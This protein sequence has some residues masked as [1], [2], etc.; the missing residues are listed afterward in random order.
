MSNEN[1]RAYCGRGWLHEHNNSQ[2]VNFDFDNQLYIDGT[3]Y[4]LE[5][6]MIK[7]QENTVVLN[8]KKDG[9]AFELSVQDFL[10]KLSESNNSADFSLSVEK[11]KKPKQESKDKEVQTL[12]L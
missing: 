3:T 7:P 10:F 9:T 2:F 4:D 1:K 5:S 12:S 6:I 8:A 11:R